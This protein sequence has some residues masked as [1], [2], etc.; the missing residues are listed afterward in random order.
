MAYTLQ[1]QILS[2]TKPGLLRHIKT[3][4]SFRPG[5]WLVGSLD[6]NMNF[7]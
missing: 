2:R 5:F 4:D 1:E 6:L 7:S 3:H